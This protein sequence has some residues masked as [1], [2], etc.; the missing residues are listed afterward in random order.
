MTDSPSMGTL[1]RVQVKDLAVFHKNAR[2]GDVDLIAN[3]MEH[4]GVYKPLVVNRGTHTGRP[5]EVLCGNHS[6]MAMRRLAD[7][8]PRDGRWKF[9]DVYVVDVD[10]DRAMRLVLVDNAANDKSTYD[11]EELVNLATE[12]PDLEA[13]GFSRDELDKMLEALEDNFGGDEDEGEESAPEPEGY[14]LIVECDNQN[15]RDTL[16]AKLLAEGFNVGNA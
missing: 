11:V 2:R 1:E 5:Y 13:T 14:G 12:L 10:D 7:E 4:N 15:Q 16:K 9:A 8:N 3:S 6:L